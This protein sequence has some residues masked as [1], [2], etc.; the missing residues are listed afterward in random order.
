LT[1]SYALN[2]GS[3]FGLATGST[4]PITASQSISSSWSRITDIGNPNIDYAPLFNASLIGTNGGGT[5]LFA[6]NTAT[7]SFRA[8]LFLGPLTGSSYGTASFANSASYALTASTW[9][10]LHTMHPKAG[11]TV[12]DNTTAYYGWYDDRTSVYNNAKMYIPFNGTLRQMVVKVLVTAT[13]GSAELVHHEANINGI[14]SLMVSASWNTAFL[15]A[16][17]SGSYSV[18]QGDWI[19]LKIVTPTFVT[20]PGGVRVH[21]TFG[22]TTP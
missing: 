1:A 19:A 6:F 12:T 15:T 9:Q 5:S 3:A 14:G 13:L 20:D 21:A 7:G 11:W 10:Y 2:A 22:F 17:A 18:S 8:T 16:S 4:Y